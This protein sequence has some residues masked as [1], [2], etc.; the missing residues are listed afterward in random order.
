MGG[1]SG[2]EENL[3]ESDLETPIPKLQA[4]SLHVPTILSTLI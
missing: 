2:L 1:G 4:A 3:G